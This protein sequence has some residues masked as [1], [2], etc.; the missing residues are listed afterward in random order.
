MLSQFFQFLPFPNDQLFGH[1]NS[2]L[3]LLS[4]I[5][6]VLASYIALDF[7]GR[8]RDRNNTPMSTHLWLMGGA[9]AMGA[10]IWSMHFIGMLSFTI[11]G[12]PL[13]YDLLWTAISLVVAIFASGFALFLL[14]SKNINLKHLIGGG[15]I[16]GLAI[17]SMHYTGMEAMLISLNI[18]YLPTL[19]L[20]SILIAILASE[21]AI[22]F[23]LKSNRIISRYRNRAKISSAIIMG[24]AIC[25]MHYT[26]MS[27]SVFTP[28]CTP[29][30][31]ATL[32]PSLNPTLLSIAIA[33][34]TFIILAIAFLAS[35]YR[36][37]LNQQNFERARQLGMA[38]I[39]ASVL[40]NVGNVLNSVNVS[41]H[42]LSEKMNNSK[43]ANL[44]KLDQ[45]LMDNK[46]D[47]STFLT[48][49]ERGKKIPEFISKLSTYWQQEKE[50]ISS[51]VNSVLK[52][53]LL[54]KSIISTQQ[55]LNKSQSEETILDINELMDEA[56]LITGLDLKKEIQIKKKY[57]KVPPTLVDKIKLLPILVNLF[58]NAKEALLE[59]KNENKW[60]EIKTTLSPKNR[61]VI[62]VSDNGIGI[63]KKNLEKI[64]YYGFT[65]KESGHGFGL[66]SSALSTSDLGGEINVKSEGYEKGATFILDL[67]FKPPKL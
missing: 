60:I 9:I 25:G 36:E 66:H 29:S 16:L 59:S 32:S 13:Q 1:Y 49:D 38:E 44:E 58:R 30:L 40:H 2:S 34:V 51:E 45:L 14:K 55:K 41:A 12:V 22:W 61:V 52:N 64:F 33:A 46:D 23:A 3:V 50:L 62:E 10:G 47:I 7:T 54:I 18:R 57:S 19:F 35:N 48:Q 8:L 17:A 27:A 24:I 20:L 4:V 28:L 6:A 15:I 21:A 53:I 67:P 37:A 26:G 56:L 63:L 42:V 11:P 5:V 43:L 39:S 31:S 65:T